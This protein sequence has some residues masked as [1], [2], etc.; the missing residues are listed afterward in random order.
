MKD[1]DQSNPE[2]T[3]LIEKR[4]KVIEQVFNRIVQNIIRNQP[5]SE[6][7]EITDWKFWIPS[8][9]RNLWKSTPIK[10]LHP[11]TPTIKIGIKN[12]HTVVYIP[13]EFDLGIASQSLI[14][15]TAID[16]RANGTTVENLAKIW[17]TN[18]RLSFS[19]A[20]WGYEFDQ[21]YPKHRWI[22][23]AIVLGVGFLSIFILELI[24]KFL[25][26]WDNKLR[27]K[28]KDLTE[29]I[30]LN[31]EAVTSSNLNEKAN[32][33]N[34]KETNNVSVNSNKKKVKL[35]LFL[36]EIF[37]IIKKIIKKNKWFYTQLSSSKEKIILQQQNLI[38]QQRNSYHL[39]LRV[40]FI[41]Q[42]F[43]LLASLIIITLI[44]RD[45]RF[46]SVYLLRESLNLMF[47]WIVLII[48]DKI[49]DFIIDYYLHRW[50][51]QA[52]VINPTSN[53]YTLRIN[54]YSIVLKQATSFTIF[55]LGVYG[56]IWLIGLNL[57]VLAGA[58]VLTL[59][60]AFLSRNLLEDMLN[61]ILILCTDRYAIGDVIDIGGGM[62]G[63]VEN[64]N[65]FVTSLRNLDGQVI[66]IPN[67][68]ISTVINNTKE[69]SRV[70]FTIKIAWNEDIKK[71]ISV[72]TQVANQMQKEP[73]WSRK[74]LDP[75]EVLGVDDVSHEGIVIHVLIRTQ[76]SEHWGIGREFRFRVKHAFDE[77]GISLG[78]PH[79]KIS[80]L[81][82]PN[83][84]DQSLAYFFPE[85]DN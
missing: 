47:L 34:K 61:G 19:N 37:K 23:S 28:L 57:S 80:V 18:I 54:T 48:L 27:K 11:W 66:A 39:L 73:E 32:N 85:E 45:A 9:V 17:Q 40:S 30:T 1:I 52:Q 44:F 22:F 83:N 55:I 35:L 24:R 43:S 25:R 2:V 81:N 64:I 60:L 36:N 72:M 68:K 67:S 53:R 69:W 38:E 15:V 13:D 62:A 50:A 79:H 77:A 8:S 56:S 51:N 33:S 5:N 42:L 10:P 3:Q 14:T 71:A 70:N 4:A 6:K 63:L 59:A 20:F 74:I 65:L 75:I 76:P 7:I 16:A 21:R 58:G 49:T 31:P 82:S 78:I 12:N 41:F 29:S 46:L 26:T 84:N